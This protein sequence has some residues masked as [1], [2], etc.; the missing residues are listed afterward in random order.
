M[1]EIRGNEYSI[2]ISDEYIVQACKQSEK[3]TYS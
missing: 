2:T 3:I 1:G